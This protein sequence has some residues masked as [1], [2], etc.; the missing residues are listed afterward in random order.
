MEHHI[1]GRDQVLVLILIVPDLTDSVR[2]APVVAD[3]AVISG[4][5]NLL[6]LLDFLMEANVNETFLVEKGLLT[7]TNHLFTVGFEAKSGCWSDQD[8]AW[9]KITLVLHLSK[10]SIELWLVLRV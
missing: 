10:I 9:G 5:L 6:M 7:L 8:G 4:D 1:V 2:Q 3:L